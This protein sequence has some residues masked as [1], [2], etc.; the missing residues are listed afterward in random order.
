MSKK[1]SQLVITRT[2][3]DMYEITVFNSKECIQNILAPKGETLLQVEKLMKK[4]ASKG[5]L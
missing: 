3:K 1:L 4:L 2:S 5:R